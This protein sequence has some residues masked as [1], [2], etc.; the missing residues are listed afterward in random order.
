MVVT[1]R[2]SHMTKRMF[3]IDKFI[4]DFIIE[5]SGALIYKLISHLNLNPRMV[6]GKLT[7]SSFGPNLFEN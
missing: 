1:C 2:D 4:Q 3:Y 7:C 5:R 6:A